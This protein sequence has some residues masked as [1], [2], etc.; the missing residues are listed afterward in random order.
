MKS[1]RGVVGSFMTTF[2]ATIIIVL[3]LI[4]FVFMSSMVKIASK[5]DAG[6][7][8]HKEDVIGIDDG[9]GYM[10]N[11]VKLVEARGKVWDNVSLDNALSEVGYEK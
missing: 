10:D 7:V 9:V 2:I 11:Y 5:A 6:L 4:G 1:K 3:I 8:V